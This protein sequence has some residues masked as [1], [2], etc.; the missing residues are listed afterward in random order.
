LIQ[1][2]A[3]PS[4]THPHMPGHLRPVN[5]G[6][7]IDQLLVYSG[8]FMVVQRL[9]RFSDLGWLINHE[10]LSQPGLRTV[11]QYKIIGYTAHVDCDFQSSASPADQNYRQNEP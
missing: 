6:T 11:R 4:P 5:T 10:R 2:L 8:E 9:P 3:H 1:N 7:I